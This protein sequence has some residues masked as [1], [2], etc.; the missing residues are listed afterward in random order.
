MKV[1]PLEIVSRIDVGMSEKDAAALAASGF[2]PITVRDIDGRLHV[3]DG[4]RRFTAAVLLLPEVAVETTQA[5]S[6]R[7]D[8]FHVT[9]LNTMLRGHWRV[10]ADAAHETRTHLSV[11]RKLMPWTVPQAT[12]RRRV[13]IRV[14]YTGNRPPDDDN[15][16]KLLLDGLVKEGLLVDDSYQWCECH[17]GPPRKSRIPGVVL[18]IEDIPNVSE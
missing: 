18:V 14:N 8:H 10:R 17:G 2:Q 15:V 9:S 7:L 16:R 4:L 13:T 1:H 6:I 11:G 5:W 3:V 12:G